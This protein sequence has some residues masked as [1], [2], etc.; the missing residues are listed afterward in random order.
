V[1]K[2]GLKH[3]ILKGLKIKNILDSIEMPIKKTNV[4]RLKALISP[5]SPTKAQQE[6]VVRDYEQRKIANYLTAENLILKLQSSN[7]KLVE[8]TLRDILKY[9]K[10]EPATGRLSIQSGSETN[11]KVIGETTDTDAKRKNEDKQNFV[12]RCMGDEVMKKDYPD[13]KQRIAICLS[14]SKPKGKSSLI[15]EVHDHLLA[16]NYLW[17]DTWDEFEKSFAHRNETICTRSTNGCNQITFG[18]Q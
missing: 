4:N 17:D 18:R 8:K 14:Q 7:K 16:D 1:F 12:A 11:V 2:N 5:K 6:A 3:F 13:T 15:E 9:E 10:A